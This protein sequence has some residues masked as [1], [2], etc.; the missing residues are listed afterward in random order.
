MP[1]VAGFLVSGMMLLALAGCAIGLNADQARLC[2]IILPVLHPEGTK[3]LVLR[4]S[5]LPGQAGVELA[6][7]TSLGGQPSRL[8]NVSCTFGGSFGPDES[9]TGQAGLTGLSV[10]GKAWSDGRVALLRRFWLKTPE[11]ASA[12]PQPVAGTGVSASISP[13]LAYA[14]Q[15]M[16]NAIAPCS[17][18]ALLA[19]AYALVYG[20][21]GRIN[22]A[23][24]ELAAIG[25]YAALYGILVSIG[26]P[27]FV[28]IALACLLALSAAASYGMASAKLVFMPLARASGQQALVATIGLS[29]FLQ[30][31]L[32]LT[33]GAS[34][35]WAAPQ[36]NIPMALVRAEDF[37]VTITP[38]I[39]VMG[40]AALAAALGLLVLMAKSRFGRQWRAYADDPLAA[41]LFGISAKT[42]FGQTFVLASGMAGLAGAQMT[43]LY[44]GVGYGAS[45]SLG[46]KALIAAILGGITSVRG[47]MM[48]G[49]AVGVIEALWSAWFPIV[50]RDLVIELLLVAIV[51][52]RP[53]SL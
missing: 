22:L 35:N 20:L 11:G 41:A 1:R 14:L 16:V 28:P 38:I 31:F 3:L 5:S 29:L 44:G 47:A 42:L 33:Q 30:E 50:Y 51:V 39:L 18:Y 32:R 15:Q 37:T 45:T 53:R 52:F 27:A 13:S 9:P 8:H 36:L 46:L 48:G 19:A 34:L 21:V 23:F 25:G 49:L 40:L 17:I 12:D 6:Y 24:G 43:L 10:D 26:S 7:R 2:R 4:Q